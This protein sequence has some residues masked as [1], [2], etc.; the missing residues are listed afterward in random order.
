MNAMAEDQVW[1]GFMSCL[2]SVRTTFDKV[3]RLQLGR[4]LRTP[5]ST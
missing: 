5:H 4:A 1:G 2:G 3:V